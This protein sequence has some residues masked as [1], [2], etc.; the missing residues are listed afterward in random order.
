M[1]SHSYSLNLTW[2]TGKRGILSSS[3]FNTEIEVVTPPP[4]NGGTAGYWSPEHLL[5]A[6]VSSCLM[7]TFLAIAEN[8]KFEFV[9]FNCDASGKLEMVEGKYLITEITLRTELK[10]FDEA[11]KEKAERILVKAEKACLISNSIKSTVNMIPT[12]V[13]ETADVI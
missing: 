6:S 10:I 12:V 5:V 3:E 7:T 9:W 13:V 4:F 8:S 1:E 11:H 2:K